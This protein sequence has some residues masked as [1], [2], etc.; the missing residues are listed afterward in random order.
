M[1]SKE[2]HAASDEVLDTTLGC[3]N[4]F[5]FI[6]SNAHC[7]VTEDVAEE[8]TG[9][10]GVNIASAGQGGGEGYRVGECTCCRQRT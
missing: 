4:G 2:G 7:R 3:I 9:A 6:W 10:R 8:F 5:S 1:C